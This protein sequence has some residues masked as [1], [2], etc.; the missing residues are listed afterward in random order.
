M[1]WIIV[2]LLLIN[3]AILLN[4]NYKIKGRDLVQEALDRDQR[5]GRTVSRQNRTE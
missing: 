1:T 2:I 3:T 5:R 4:I